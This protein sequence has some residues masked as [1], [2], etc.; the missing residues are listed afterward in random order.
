MVG[1]DGSLGG[2]GTGE[3]CRRCGRGCMPLPR[4][5]TPASYVCALGSSHLPRY[6]ARVRRMIGFMVTGLMA[7]IT[8]PAG[9]MMILFGAFPG[10][11]VITAAQRQE[12]VILVF[13]GVFF[14]IAGILC[15]ITA[16][17][18]RPRPGDMQPPPEL[19]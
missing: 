18:I 4:F 15:T 3:R 17:R 12:R 2:A 1:S 8:V 9:A 7:I 5:G 11:A 13:G 19:D 10:E 16:I 6:A 14:L